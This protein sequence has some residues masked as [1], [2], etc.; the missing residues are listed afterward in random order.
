VSSAGRVIATGRDTEILEHG[1]GR[2]LRRPRVPRSLVAEAGLMRWVAG[3][4]YPC[5][6]VFDVGDEGLVM[7]RIDG[8]SMLD[9]LGAHPW[10][11][12]THATLL[13]DL[14]GWLHRLPVPPG[15]AQP[16]GPGPALLHADLHPGNIMLS[17]D[18]PI[19]IDWS[20]AAQ[21]PAGAD[22][23]VTWLLMAAGQTE[24][25]PLERL[26][27]PALRRIL[28]RTFLRTAGRERAAASLAAVLERRRQDPNLSA[29]ELETMRRI[30]ERHGPG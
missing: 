19:V 26:A 16:F 13:A 7:A 5:P 23:A 25:S 11:V 27:V 10:R 9:D 4:G 6:E 28:V 21:G 24:S 22:M 3:H 2:V 15:L 29:H 17:A 12:R 14:H 18:G 30:V 1:P 8:V 20:N